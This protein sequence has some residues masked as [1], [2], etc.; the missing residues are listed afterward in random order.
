MRGLMMAA[1]L[2]AGL[3]GV[4]AAAPALAADNAMQT[5]GARYQAAKAGKSLPAGQTWPQFLA[6]CRASLPKTATTPVKG[7]TSAP[8]KTAA[9]R[10]PTGQPSTAQ[11]AAHSRQKQCS[12]NYQA[13]KAAN[14]L[15]GQ[16]WPKYYSACN[17]KLK[18]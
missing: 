16:S 9:A 13:D 18:G 14:K 15:A 3:T 6:Q 10:T 2:A 4:G 1:G 7:V 5:C 11:I 8:G 12:Q 17:T